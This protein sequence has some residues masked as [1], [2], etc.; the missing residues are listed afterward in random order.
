ML[1]LWPTLGRRI[2]YVAV[3]ECYADTTAAPHTL[4]PGQIPRERS[5]DCIREDGGLAVT[6]FRRRRAHRATGLEPERT[7]TSESFKTNMRH[8]YI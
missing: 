4:G 6:P 2:L 5:H 8:T 3:F 1:D 7:C